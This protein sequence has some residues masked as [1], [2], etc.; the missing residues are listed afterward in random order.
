[1]HFFPAIDFSLWIFKSEKSLWIS[2]LNTCFKKYTVNKG[3]QIFIYFLLTETLFYLGCAEISGQNIVPLTRDFLFWSSLPAWSKQSWN[4]HR[5]P[6]ASILNWKY[7]DF[8]MFG[9]CL[10]VH[11][12]HQSRTLEI[13]QSGLLCSRINPVDSMTSFGKK[14][15]DQ[16]VPCSTAYL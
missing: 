11:R 13:T 5:K 14:P 1:M 15:S 10:K 12:G 9:C 4:C 2:A 3:V 7:C 16:G 8:K 6:G